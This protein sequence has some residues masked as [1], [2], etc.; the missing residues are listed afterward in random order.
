MTVA[1]LDAADDGSATIWSVG[2]IAVLFLVAAAVLALGSVVA[3]AA[4][5]HGC[6]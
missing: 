2:G 5:G 4:S 3:D 6:R 1:R